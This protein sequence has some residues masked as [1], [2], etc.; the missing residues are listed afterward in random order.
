MWTATKFE[1]EGVFHLSE[2]P[3]SNPLLLLKTI[4]GFD[5]I[6]SVHLLRREGS[7]GRQA[8]AAG[9]RELRGIPFKTL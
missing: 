8:G 3:F 5:I 7:G 9:K 6:A 1:S 4:G 2:N